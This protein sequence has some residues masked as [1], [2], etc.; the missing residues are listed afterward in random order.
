VL[1]AQSSEGEATMARRLWVPV[2]VA[3]LV[4]VLVGPTVVATAEPRVTVTRTVTISSAAF[5]PISDNVDYYASV[6]ELR[7]ESGSGTFFAPVSFD[8]PAVTIKKVTFYAVDAG[9]GNLILGL[10]R[11]QPATGVTEHLGEVYTTGTSWTTQVV[12]LNDLYAR[13]ITGA[14]TAVLMVYLP[15][16][17]PNGYKFIAAKV[18]YSYEA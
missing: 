7:T 8:A 14:N 13:R 16:T 4:A 12:T 3:L 6:D 17:Y 18:T 2:L 15:D 5:A 11:T 9:S 10:Y 1:S